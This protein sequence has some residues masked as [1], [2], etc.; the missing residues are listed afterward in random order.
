MPHDAH[1][2]RKSRLYMQV[3]ADKPANFPTAPTLNES[4]DRVD[5]KGV[6]GFL[7]S[8]T[9][10]TRV[11]GGNDPANTGRARRQFN[12]FEDFTVPAFTVEYNEET[13]SKFNHGVIHKH[14]IHFW[15]RKLGDGAG[16]PQE[17]GWIAVTGVTPVD[18]EG[19]LGWSLTVEGSEG[20]HLENQA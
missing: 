11:K 14:W 10:G 12:G 5:D 17:R 18:L 6:Y 1:Q 15:L 3:F 9:A 2:R 4:A 7:P 16:L 13:Q 8:P 19:G 20:L